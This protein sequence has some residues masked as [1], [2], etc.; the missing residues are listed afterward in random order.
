[1]PSI[2][3]I[4]R[5]AGPSGPSRAFLHPGPPRG[6][7]AFIL[8]ALLACVACATPRIAAA[9]FVSGLTPP[10]PRPSAGEV[11]AAESVKVVRRDSVAREQRLDMRAWVDS[12]AASL[13]RGGRPRTP[14]PTTPDSARRDT[15]PPLPTPPR[16]R[17]STAPAPR[18]PAARAPVRLTA[19]FPRATRPPSSDARTGDGDRG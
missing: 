8:A 15:V 1:M 14:I 19:G 9:Q 7:Q 12:A 5:G 3:V 4:R 6:I 2:R 10:P 11:A 13:E 17:P 16:V 18:S